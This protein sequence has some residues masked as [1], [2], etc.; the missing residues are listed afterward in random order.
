M[1]G[2]LFPI[3][4]QDFRKNPDKYIEI[5]KKRFLNP[6]PAYKAIELDKKWREIKKKINDLRHKRNLLSRIYSELKDRKLKIEEIKE[7]YGKFFGNLITEIEK[8]GIEGI[9]KISNITNEEIVKLEKEEKIL[10]EELIN[11][12][13]LFPQEIDPKVP[14]GPDER[15]N[16]AIKYIG[17]PKV[18][19]NYVEEFRKNY[20]NV[21]IAEIEHEPK[22][23][24]DL[25]RDFNLVDTETAGIM[26]GSR[27]YIEKNELVFLDLALS[28]YALEFYKKR[29]FEFA[30]ITP[31]L[32]RK[33]IEKKIV[34]Y[35]AF[36]EAIYHVVEDDLILIPTS[37]HPI[38]AMFMNKIFEEKD[39]PK[40]ILAWSVAFRKEAGAHGKDT[41]G[42]FRTH[43]FHKVELHSITTLEE[44]EKE[45]EFLIKVFSEFIESLEL[46]HRI[47]VL[48]SGDMDRRASIQYDLEAWFPAENKY[49][50]LG[51]IATM[52]DWISRKLNIKVRKNGKLEFVSNLYSTGC[53]IQRTICCMLEN[54]YNFDENVIKIPKVLKKYLEFDEIYPKLKS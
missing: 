42:I 9:K 49:R 43:Q 44:D 48:S 12:F 14:I 16:V 5:F 34:Y 6:E 25:V 47:V 32:M 22:H 10:L 41:K 39:L 11:T 21:E 37:E 18:Y 27:F 33:E 30:I 40:R 3:N 52:K 2:V 20:G 28:M 36:K 17:R 26:S 45:L 4:I 53:A 7:K 35:E 24:Y 23:H 54:Y 51:S 8:N 31:Y 19:K 15:Y 29:G 1:Y 50:E 13:Y 38:A 46:P